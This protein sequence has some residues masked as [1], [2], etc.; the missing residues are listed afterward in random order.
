M[1]PDWV[2]DIRDQCESAGVPFYF[3][4][5]GGRNKKKTGRVLDGRLWNGFPHV[6]TDDH[7]SVRR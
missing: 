5:W 1:D 6:P 4:Q 2:I 7:A 3:K